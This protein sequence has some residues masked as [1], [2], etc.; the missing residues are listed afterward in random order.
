MSTPTPEQVKAE[1]DKANKESDAKDA[2][3][4]AEMKGAAGTAGLVVLAIVGLAGVGLY[5]IFSKPKVRSNGKRR[6]R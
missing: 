5:K 3:D 4:L 2:K 1:W 6:R